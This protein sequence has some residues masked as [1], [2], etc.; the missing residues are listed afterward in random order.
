MKLFATIAAGAVA[1]SAL[2]AVV[3]ASAQQ[4]VVHERVVHER[5]VVRHGGDRLHRHRQVCTTR[6]YHH[7]RVRTCR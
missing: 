1:A 3:P 5:T 6:Y 4:R 2:F 7:R